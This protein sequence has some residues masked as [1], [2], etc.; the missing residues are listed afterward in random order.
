[1]PT[2]DRRTFLKLMGLSATAGATG[3]LSACN[4]TSTPK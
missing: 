2:I 3:L 4:E 1:M